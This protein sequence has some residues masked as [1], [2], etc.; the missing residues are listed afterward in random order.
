MEFQDFPK[1]ADYM[2]KVPPVYPASTLKEVAKHMEKHKTPVVAVVGED[3]SLLGAI[4]ITLLT[5]PFIPDF[6]DYIDDFCYVS[7]FGA[8]EH[9]I[10]S[11]EMHQLF[12]ATDV[13]VKDYPYVQESDSVVK[14]L[15]SIYKRNITGLIVCTNSTYR[16]IISRFDLLKFLYDTDG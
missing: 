11:G 3:N 16:G 1:V 12:L 10:F 5:K 2:R 14:A 6:I 9:K 13:M 4:D 15:F 8:L 7:N